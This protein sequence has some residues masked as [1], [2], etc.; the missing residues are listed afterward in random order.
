MIILDSHRS[1]SNSCTD[2]VVINENI[3]D[4]KKQ[5]KAS[6][7]ALANYINGMK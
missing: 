7:S 5:A 3:T 1:Q 6:S 2:S 4:E